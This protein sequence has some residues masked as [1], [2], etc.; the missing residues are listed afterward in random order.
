MWRYLIILTLTGCSALSGQVDDEIIDSTVVNNEVHV[1]WIRF[2]DPV[3]LEEECLKL[4][5]TVKPFH[6]IRACATFN[7]EAKTCTIY[8]RNPR[9]LN[10]EAMNSLGH[11]IKHCFDGSFHD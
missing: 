3:V 11:E 2:E 10:G 1:K 9:T 4:G 5:L 7:L 6:A 8:V